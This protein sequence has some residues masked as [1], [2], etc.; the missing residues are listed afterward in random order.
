MEA[1]ASVKATIS[2]SLAAVPDADGAS[3]MRMLLQAEK[4]QTADCEYMIHESIPVWV[5][6]RYY[7]PPEQWEYWEFD[8]KLCYRPDDYRGEWFFISGVNRSRQLG[9]PTVTLTIWSQQLRKQAAGILMAGIEERP[10]CYG[11]MHALLLGYRAMLPK[12]VQMA[13]RRTGTMH[14]FAISGLHVGIICAV[15]VFLIGLL[16]VPRT[17]RVLAL[18]PVILVYALMTGARA[19]AIRAGLMAVIYLAA[20]LF[21]RRADAWSA[22]GLSGILILAWQPDQ[23]HDLGFIFSFT[24]VAGILAIVPLFEIWLQRHLPTDPFQER[25]KGMGIKASIWLWLGRLVAVSMAA[26]LS[27]TPLSIYFFGRFAPIALIAN[28]LVV[29]LAFL[30][31]VSGC[32]ALLAAAIG[33]LSFAVVFNLA[34]VAYVGLLVKGM[35][36]LERVPLGYAEN[37]TIGI[38][39]VLLWYAVLIAVVLYLRRRIGGSQTLMV[40]RS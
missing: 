36:L 4:V 32:L 34:N 27:T 19:S 25:D 30:I 13:F 18:A 8:G 35:A 10:A 2:G 29:P 5:Y 9:P 16:R 26:W 11:V 21:G 22:L 7:W 20:P 31:V 3:P 15:F 17:C 37:I 38:R 28:L 6:G 23:L 1:G 12:D 40:S 33:G 14:V 24:A 39:P